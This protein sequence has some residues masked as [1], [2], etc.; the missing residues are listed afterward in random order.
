MM[1]LETIIAL[2]EEIAAEAAEE[3]SVPFVPNNKSNVEQWPPFPFPSLGHHE[4]DGW[5]KTD[6]QWFVDS[7]GVGH[8]WE[9]A[10]S[11][12]QFKRALID[13]IADHPGDGFAIVEEGQFQVMVAAFRPKARSQAA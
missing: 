2:N 10:L 1:S 8:D 3:N 11:V 6:S 13:H 5:E 4:P 9:P 7:T 12:D